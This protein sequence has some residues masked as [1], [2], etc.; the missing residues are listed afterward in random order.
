MVAIGAAKG[1]FPVSLSRMM[2]IIIMSA[3]KEI[4]LPEA[5]EMML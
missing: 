1:L 5:W 3:E 4:H 2:K